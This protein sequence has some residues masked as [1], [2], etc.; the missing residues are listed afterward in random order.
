MTVQHGLA[1]QGH[2]QSSVW[3]QKHIISM[4]AVCACVFVDQQWI[5]NT[6]LRVR[7]YAVM[8]WVFRTMRLSR[9]FSR[10]SPDACVAAP[11][12]KA[13]F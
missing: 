4:C 11:Q 13:V 12:G 5:S 10:N 9:L 7:V 2:A 8:P 1:R 6:T 3:R